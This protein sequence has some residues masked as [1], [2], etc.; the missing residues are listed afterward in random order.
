MPDDHQTS[1]I[2]GL[3]MAIEVSQIRVIAVKRPP[4]TDSITKPRASM[5]FCEF[6]F[7]CS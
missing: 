1:T 2:V 5:F 3:E 6:L 7:I 4:M